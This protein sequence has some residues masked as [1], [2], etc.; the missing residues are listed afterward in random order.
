M[1]RVVL[2]LCCG[3][4]G[5]ARGFIDAGWIVV[6][7]D[8][9]P[10][11]YPGHFCLGDVRE[12]DPEAWRGVDLVVASPPCTEFS[13]WDKPCWYPRDTLSPPDLSITEACF[14]IAKAIGCPIILENVRGA[15]AFIGRSVA[16]YGSRYLWGD[17]VP[18]LLPS[19]PPSS[20][21]TGKGK[22]AWLSPRERAIIPYPL[23]RWIADCYSDR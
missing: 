15:Q 21:T 7:F 14:G 16:R 17:G 19:A 11:P 13:K 5:W 18:A 8:V 10:L 6:G 1:E 22:N 2:D 12:V 23:A 4:G 3:L 20:K 9:E